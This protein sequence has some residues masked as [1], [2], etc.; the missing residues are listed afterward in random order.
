M[1]SRN[2]KLILGIYLSISLGIIGYFYINPTEVWG[3]HD[4]NGTYNYYDIPK[5][6]YIN[7]KYSILISTVMGILI[8]SILQ[9]MTKTKNLN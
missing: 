2:K 8:Y 6:D 1:N 3:H 5:Y 9:F 4:N 7:F